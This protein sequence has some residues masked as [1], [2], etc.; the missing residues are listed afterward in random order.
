[1]TYHA[2]LAC[3]CVACWRAHHCLCAAL[4]NRIC[5]LP[6][7]SAVF[8]KFAECGIAVLSYDAYGHGQSDPQDKCDRAVVWSFN[9]LVNDLYFVWDWAKKQTPANAALPTFIGGQS[10]GGLVAA[11]TALRSQGSWAGCLLHSAAIDVEW[12][13]VLR[14]AG[15][16]TTA[17]L[18]AFP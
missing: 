5:L 16:Q 9:D 18:H 1:M 3:A 2:N 4:F 11:H 15:T 10:M 6:L 12:T 13:P 17:G 7:L 14:C 8:T